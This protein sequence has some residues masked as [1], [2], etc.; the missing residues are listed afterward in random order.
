MS[1]FTDMV[2]LILTIVSMLLV[3]WFAIAI[4]MHDTACAVFI[5]VLQVFAAMIAVYAI[6]NE[7]RFP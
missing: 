3:A 2:S 1:I 6:R 7:R 5:I 4:S